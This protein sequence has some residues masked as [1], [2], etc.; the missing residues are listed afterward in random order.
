[1]WSQC[2]TFLLAALTA[3][4]L[5]APSPLTTSASTTAT[6][7]GLSGSAHDGILIHV[8]R[9]EDL[10]A[11]KLKSKPLLLERLSHLLIQVELGNQSVAVN[12]HHLPM[13]PGDQPLQV[14]VK[15]KQVTM[16]KMPDESPLVPL[17]LT[18]P[19]VLNIADK[20]MSEGIVAA[21]LSVTQEPLAVEATRPNHSPVQA[22]AYKVT[23][24]IKIL[25]VD[26]MA[27]AATNLPTIDL[28][29]LVVHPD[30]ADPSKVATV[31]TLVVDAPVAS[32]APAGLPFTPAGMLD[33]ALDSTRASLES[34][35]NALSSVMQGVAAQAGTLFN[36][37]R[38][39]KPC[40]QRPHHAPHDKV[41]AAAVHK[42]TAETKP[43]VQL[44]A[45]TKDAE[46]EHPVGRQSA[47]STFRRRMNCFIKMV[48]RSS[49]AVLLFGLPFAFVFLV[50]STLVSSLLR[51]R[52]EASVAAAE[53]AHIP[54]VYEALPGDEKLA[55][56]HQQI[57]IIAAPDADKF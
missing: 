42:P 17:G 26:G 41:P 38:A 12:G 1:M 5:A 22:E 14:S 47:V 48:A 40:H 56:E 3:S 30:E 37:S 43:A 31:T 24:G 39:R 8:I 49:L 32:Q 10:I 57:I 45:V 6:L 34:T 54:P 46:P 15:L 51:R 9:T 28:L 13:L 4:S 27:L 21:L 19:E 25:E 29:H 16:L 33:A 11:D 7:S 44:A 52:L 18:P 50:L 23:I 20:Y 2:L 35:L 53:S 55:L 36:A